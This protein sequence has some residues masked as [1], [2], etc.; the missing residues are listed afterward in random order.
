M[1]MSRSARTAGGA[2][3]SMGVGTMNGANVVT[4]TR[5]A[6]SVSGF[7]ASVFAIASQRGIARIAQQFTKH[8]DAAAAGSASTATHVKTMNSR[9]I[10]RSQRRYAARK[11][12]R[13]ARRLAE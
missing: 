9:F 12:S 10:R 2:G 6:F 8:C 1:P 3:S 5:G 7:A 4:I 13:K 11:F